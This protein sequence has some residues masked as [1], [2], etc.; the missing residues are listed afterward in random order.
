MNEPLDPNDLVTLRNAESEF[1]AGILVAV[2]QEAGI[3]AFAF[4]GV[5]AAMPLG[6]R[7]TPVAVQVR[8]VDLE[9]A[10]EA[11]KQNASD[12]VDL[13]WDEVDVGERSDRLPLGSRDG[14]PLIPKLGFWV[15]IIII[16]SMLVGGAIVT[17][18]VVWP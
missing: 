13:D 4:G 11:L 2:L 18:F 3:E 8:Q 7:I 6:Q 17:K 5:T 15:A 10:T 9:R 14:L 16:A 1:Q 12:S